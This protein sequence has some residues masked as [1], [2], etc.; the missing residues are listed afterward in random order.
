MN[1]SFHSILISGLIVFASLINMVR[2]QEVV[3]AKSTTS[4]GF[5]YGVD[6][7]LDSQGNLFVLGHGTSAALTLDSLS[8]TSN[9]RSDAFIAK[10]SPNGQL[11]WF[12]TLGGDDNNYYDKA[13]D[14]HVDNNDDVIVLVTAASNNFTYNGN[15]LPGIN[16]SAQY[17]GEGVIMKI[18]NN[19]NYLWHDDGSTGSSFQNVVTDSTGNV[20]LTGWFSGLITLGDTIHLNNPTPAGKDMFIAKYTSSGKI[21]WAKPVGGNTL[22]TNAYGHNIAIDD[23]TGNVTVL[24]RYS[25]SI[26]FTSDTLTTTHPS[27]SFLVTY[28]S[29]GTELW[30][31]SLFSNAYSFCQGLDISSTGLIG[32]AG[33]NS[34][35]HSAADGLV[36]FYDTIGNIISENIISS[37]YTC[38]LHSLT[39]NQLDECY[40]SGIFRDSLSFGKSPHKISLKAD[41]QSSGLIIKL[42]NNLIP[43][44]ANQLSSSSE[45]KISCKN[46]RVFFSSRFDNPFIYNYGAD[47]INRTG[48]A[49]FAEIADTSCPLVLRTDTV[50]ECYRFTWIDG[51]T[52]TSDNDTATF[53]IPKGAA[54][55]C[56]TL[57]TL[58]LTINTVSDISTSISNQTITANNQSASY[59]WLDCNNGYAIIPNETDQSFTPAVNGSYAVQLTENGCTDTSACL[60]I[61]DI[62]LIQNDFGQ[63]FSLY[64]N[65]NRGAFSID[66][67]GIQQNLI[68]TIKDL[69]GKTILTKTYRDS[70]F[71]NIELDKPA[72]VYLLLIESQ[73]KHAAIRLVQY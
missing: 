30:V 39:F 18:D 65:P 70:D 63:E 66:L 5:E 20:Y 23:S 55:G 2:A 40:I 48:D 4:P 64:P 52:Y 9:G 29:L 11:L 50:V 7:D 1:S 6:S 32:V 22:N 43:I 38:H 44:W 37:T 58:K 57:V 51:K 67:G 28:N 42:S 14:I 68:L 19:G 49:V 34:L 46:N 53:Y 62:G 12:K 15:I 73:N 27:S 72:G 47:T 36:G 35:Y 59:Q 10:F 31:K 13:M 71:L 33:Y 56:N 3:W 24:G 60:E 8:L 25:K 17:G 61:A 54:N 21:L 41:A 69:N 26:F 45:N 16:S